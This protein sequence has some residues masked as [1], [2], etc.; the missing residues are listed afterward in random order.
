MI[1]KARPVRSF[2]ANWRWRWRAAAASLSPELLRQFNALHLTF[3]ICSDPGPCRPGCLSFYLSLS[4]SVC[5]P[6]QGLCLPLH[7]CRYV[8]A[9]CV[10]VCL[11]VCTHIACVLCFAQFVPLFLMPVF[12]RVPS[13]GLVF[14]PDSTS[15][16]SYSGMS[17]APCGNYYFV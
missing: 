8:P 10:P 6:P 2:R 15:S 14:D 11:C 4:L 3:G 13:S 7:A 5:E 1:S 12:C 9:M 17:F 16:R